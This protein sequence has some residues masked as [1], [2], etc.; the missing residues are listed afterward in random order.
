[1]LL[2][3]FSK[4]YKKTPCSIEKIFNVSCNIIYI[5]YGGTKPSDATRVFVDRTVNCLL[6]GYA[7]S[8]GARKL[9]FIIIEKLQQK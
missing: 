5:C 8:P 6:R 7:R 1:M 9:V 3:F 4:C 2:S